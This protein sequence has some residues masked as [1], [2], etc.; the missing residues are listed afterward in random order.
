MVCAQR[1]VGTV[2]RFN[3]RKQAGAVF[4][5]HR[6]RGRGVFGNTVRFRRPDVAVDPAAAVADDPVL[7]LAHISVLFDVRVDELGVHWATNITAMDGNPVVLSPGQRAE[8]LAQASVPP[9]C[10]GLRFSKGIVIALSLQPAP[11][12]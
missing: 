9:R 11:P 10:V 3:V 1:L 8:T 4:T 5:H 6:L 7:L 2:K 12:L